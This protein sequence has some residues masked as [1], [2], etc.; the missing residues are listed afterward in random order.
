MCAPVGRWFWHLKNGTVFH[1][2]IA[3]AEPYAHERALGWIGHYAV[4]ILYGVVLALLAGAAGAQQ[5]DYGFAGLMGK[6]NRV[7][8]APLTLGS[9]KPVVSTPYWHARELLAS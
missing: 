9:G 6:A 5:F 4:G 1:D 8:I 2:D 7:E 3:R